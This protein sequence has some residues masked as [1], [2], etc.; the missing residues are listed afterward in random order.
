MFQKVEHE[1]EP[2][3]PEERRQ[4]IARL[5]V[6]VRKEHVDEVCVALEQRTDLA[7]SPPTACDRPS[8]TTRW[9]RT[10]GGSTGGRALMLV[11]TVTSAPAVASAAAKR[12]TK[13]APPF[14]SGG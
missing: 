7:N 9:S 10:P 11:I 13:S 6:G 1:R 4:L 2:A 14:R 5:K 12:A 3:R 8:S